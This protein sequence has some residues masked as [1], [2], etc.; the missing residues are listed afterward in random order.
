MCVREM[1]G[2]PL[3]VLYWFRKGFRGVFHFRI[4]LGV[5]E[6]CSAASRPGAEAVELFWPMFVRV[7]GHCGYVGVR[8]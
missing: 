2:G 4:S 7:C 5:I 6:K 1:L 8:P 3:A